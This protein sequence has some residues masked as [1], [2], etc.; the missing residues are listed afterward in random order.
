MKPSQ[1]LAGI[2]QW[3]KEGRD[4]PLH[5]GALIFDTD[6]TLQEHVETV[7][8]EAATLE[9]QAVLLAEYILANGISV[10]QHV[11]IT[12]ASVERKLRS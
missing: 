10:P 3:W 7:A 5:P 8:T 9:R 12:A 1:L 4:S 2:A 11:R 6:D